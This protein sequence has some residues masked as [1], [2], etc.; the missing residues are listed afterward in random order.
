MVSAWHPVAT[1]PSPTAQIPMFISALFPFPTGAGTLKA[2]TAQCCSGSPTFRP[3]NFQAKAQPT[4]RKL[5][6]TTRFSNGCLHG[7]PVG[8]THFHCHVLVLLAALSPEGI[9]TGWLV[10]WSMREDRESF[11]E[12]KDVLKVDIDGNV[13][14]KEKNK[15]LIDAFIED[16]KAKP[17]TRSR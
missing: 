8:L 16:C 4:R 7:F 12:L 6:F 10:G 14:G 17:L 2:L 11:I 15:R 5:L 1:N 9:V 13:I 3:F